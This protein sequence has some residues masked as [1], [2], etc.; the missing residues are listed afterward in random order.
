[1]SKRIDSEAI[2]VTLAIASVVLFFG[3]SLWIGYSLASANPDPI[4]TVLASA[5]NGES[6]QQTV[7]NADSTIALLVESGLDQGSVKPVFG[8]VISL[9]EHMADLKAMRD[10]VQ[11]YVAQLATS[12]SSEDST[13]ILTQASMVTERLGDFHTLYAWKYSLYANHSI[14]MIIWVVSLFGVIRLFL[15]AD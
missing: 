1:M 4:R 9:D 11:Q 5:E 10:S 6:L 14:A 3:S 8:S 15:E 7:A 2:L 13:T 12:S